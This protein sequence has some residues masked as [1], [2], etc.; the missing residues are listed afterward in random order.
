[1]PRN[2]GPQ[3]QPQAVDT[4]QCSEC[5]EHSKAHGVSVA[6]ACAN[7]CGRWAYR[8]CPKSRVLVPLLCHPFKTEEEA[9]T[10]NP[11][12]ECCECKKLHG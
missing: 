12:W 7:E 2:H 10:A 9:Q 8:T 3:R 1:M 11:P 5:N 4:E 6:V